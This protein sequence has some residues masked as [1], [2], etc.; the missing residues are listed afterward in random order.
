ML[1]AQA[2]LIRTKLYQQLLPGK[3]TVLKERYLSTE[4]LRKLWGGEYETRDNDLKEAI[5]ETNNQVLFYGDTYQWSLFIN[6]V[7]E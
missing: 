4:K 6:P 2:V 1:K 7:T 5:E 3:E